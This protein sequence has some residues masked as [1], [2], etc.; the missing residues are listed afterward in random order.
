MPY[1]PGKGIAGVDVNTSGGYD[2]APSPIR[3]PAPPQPPARIPVRDQGRR[4]PQL[5]GRYPDL[6]R[7][8]QLTLLHGA[9]FPLRVDRPTIL[10]PIRST[11]AAVAAGG[12][13]STPGTN[14]AGTIACG[15]YYPVFFR[16]ENTFGNVPAQKISADTDAMNTSQVSNGAGVIYL[17]A[18]GQWWLFGSSPTATDSTL[19]EM[20]D[21]SDSVVAARY[22]SEPGCHRIS[23]NTQVT[24]GVASSV[25]LLANRNRTAIQIYNVAAF[26]AALGFGL[27]AVTTGYLLQNPAAATPN[28]SLFMQGATCW[29]GDISAIR[30]GANDA[31]LQVIEWE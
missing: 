4:P 17:N 30:T 20:I 1:N 31:T 26:P 10:W 25:I 3:V 14:P 24:A 27:V 11:I 29:K 5:E 16:P 2:P 13:G 28:S 12:G 18:P 15:S 23:V 8:N 9:W 21:A 7:L 19:Y 22:L 6:I